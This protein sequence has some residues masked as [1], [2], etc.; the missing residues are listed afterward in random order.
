MFEL[1]CGLREIF[2]TTKSFF[3]HDS[4]QTLDAPQVFELSC[5][6]REAEQN[7]TADNASTQESLLSVSAKYAVLSFSKYT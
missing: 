1:L 6:Q 5:A 4:N 2:L 3:V 7:R